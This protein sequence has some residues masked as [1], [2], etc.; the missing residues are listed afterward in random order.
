VIINVSVD[1][2][3]TQYTLPAKPQEGEADGKSSYFELESE[4][5]EVV[6]SGKSE[7]KKTHARL[8]VTIDGKPFVGLIETEPHDHDH[9]HAH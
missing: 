2:A 7:A 1:G 3:P 8:N 4:P 6:V 5:L 9:G